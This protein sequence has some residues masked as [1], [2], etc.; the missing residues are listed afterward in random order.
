MDAQLSPLSFLLEEVEELLPDH[1]GKVRLWFLRVPP[2]S[3]ALAMDEVRLRS[4]GFGARFGVR[5]IPY[6]LPCAMSNPCIF[7]YYEY[8]MCLN[9]G[10]QPQITIDEKLG[11]K[12]SAAWL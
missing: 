9:H 1:G 8:G 4:I 5:E 6:K 3:I 10:Q 12:S 7:T 11:N 2:T